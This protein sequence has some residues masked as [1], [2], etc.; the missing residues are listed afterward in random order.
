MLSAIARARE[1]PQADWPTLDERPILPPG[2]GPIVELLKVV[3]KL[4]ADDHGVAQK[5]VSTVADI[6]RI[7]VDD[8]ADVPALKGWR[9]QVF[10]ERALAVKHGRMGLAIKDKRLTLVALDHPL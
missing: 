5:L 1:A 9:R 6:E 3:L 8:E 4:C 10:G 7:A 2:A